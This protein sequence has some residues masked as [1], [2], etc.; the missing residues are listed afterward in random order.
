MES[1]SYVY[2]PAITPN[3]QTKTCCSYCCAD[4]ETELFYLI[5]T[6]TVSPSDRKMAANSLLNRQRRFDRRRR[7]I[8]WDIP[9]PVDTRDYQ[10]TGRSPRARVI[11]APER[12]LSL[13]DFKVFRIRSQRQGNQNTPKW[14]RDEANNRRSSFQKWGAFRL[15]R[16]Q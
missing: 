7:A 13:I 15:P 3:E 9:L 16:V 8:D 5:H 12:R 6:I 4:D 11:T 10:A 14:D 1:Y 2:S